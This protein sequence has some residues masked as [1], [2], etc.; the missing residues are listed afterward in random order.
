MASFEDMVAALKAR[1]EAQE[2]EEIEL[3]RSEFK[4]LQKA[5][6]DVGIAVYQGN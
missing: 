2:R 6:S 3:L 1:H 5:K 4:R